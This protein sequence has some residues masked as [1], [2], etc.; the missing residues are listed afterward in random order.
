MRLDETEKGTEPEFVVGGTSLHRNIVTP[1]VGRKRQ[2]FASKRFA[3]CWN[4][5][6]STS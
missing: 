1:K 2:K 4:Q 3:G 5:T 6:A